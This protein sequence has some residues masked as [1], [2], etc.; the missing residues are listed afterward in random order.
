MLIPAAT[1]GARSAEQSAFIRGGAEQSAFIRGGAEQLAFI[2]G[3]AE[4]SAFIR[5]G[6][7]QSTF[8]RS[9]AE[10]RPARGLLWNVLQNGGFYDSIY[11]LSFK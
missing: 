4:Q 11:R 5:D 2:R 1:A 10:Q 7:E 6:A 9:G 3:G 8:I